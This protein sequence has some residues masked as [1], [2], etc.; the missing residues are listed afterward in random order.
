MGKDLENYLSGVVKKAGPAQNLPKNMLCTLTTRFDDGLKVRNKKKKNLFCVHSRI[1][2]NE[3]HFILIL[4]QTSV[5]FVTRVC[6]ISWTVTVPSAA[7]FDYFAKR[8]ST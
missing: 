3:C 7:I 8:N 1:K 6:P 2:Q 4:G 5:Q